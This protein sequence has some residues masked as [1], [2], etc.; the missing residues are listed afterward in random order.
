MGMKVRDLLRL[1]S[2]DGWSVVAQKGDLQ[3][4]NHDQKPG[5]ITIASDPYVDVPPPILNMALKRAGLKG[6]EVQP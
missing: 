2:E 5:K 3:T 4:L 1:L 6:Q